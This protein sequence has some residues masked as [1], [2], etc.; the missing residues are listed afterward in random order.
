MSTTAKD[1]LS[2][3]RKSQ[4][5][6]HDIANVTDLL[7]KTVLASYEPLITDKKCFS[8]GISCFRTCSKESDERLVIRRGADKE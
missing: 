4:T 5:V 6:R 7:R 3:S 8:V 1:E 2:R